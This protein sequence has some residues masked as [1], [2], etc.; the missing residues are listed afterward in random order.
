M[1]PVAGSSSSARARSRPR[2]SRAALDFDLFELA[3]RVQIPVRILWA[4][5][6]SFPRFVYEALAER[7]A[8]A[9]IEDVDAGHLMPMEAPALV[10][11]ALDR[12]ISQP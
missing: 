11:D 5:R 2:S 1:R 9:S 6:D 3:G 7:I 4:E 10:T 8:R 12:L